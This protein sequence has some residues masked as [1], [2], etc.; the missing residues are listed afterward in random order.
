VYKF[1]YIT[2]ITFLL[3]F[4][5]FWHYSLLFYLVED[6]EQLKF[7]VP[8]FKSV[9]MNFPDSFIGWTSTGICEVV[10]TVPCTTKV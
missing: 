4:R 8:Y 10:Y 3:L 7:V 5:V 2:F 6:Y 1:L 9:F